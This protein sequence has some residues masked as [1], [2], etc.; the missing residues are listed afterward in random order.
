MA[1]ARTGWASVGSRRSRL[2]STSR[3]ALMCWRS[4]RSATLLAPWDEARSSASRCA[5]WRISSGMDARSSEGQR[6]AASQYLLGTPHGINLHGPRRQGARGPALAAISTGEHLT[7][8]GRTV[9]APGLPLV[10]GD[11]EDGGL[12]LDAHVHPSPAHATVLAAEQDADVALEIRTCG[13]PDG[14]RITRDLADITAVGLS[15]GIQRFEPGAGPVLAAVGAADDTPD[16][17]GAV[18]LTGIGG[19]GGQLQDSLGRVG[20]G[21]HGYLWEADGHRELL[22]ALA[23]VLTPKDLAVLVARVQHL[24][25]ARIEQQRPNRQAVI[26]DVEPFPVLPVVH[27]AVGTVLRPHI[28]CVGVLGVR[29]Y[30]PDGGRLR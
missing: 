7:T 10:E 19:I 5:R 14:L 24:G 15:L 4:F 26:R 22:P 23:A 9:H 6:V 28:Y 21:G 3:P 17:D 13:H 20:P 11:A 16:F 1:W 29:S 12:W 8:A 18:D 25:V 2:F 27:A 30:G